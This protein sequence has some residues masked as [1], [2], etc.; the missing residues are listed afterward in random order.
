MVGPVWPV[1]PTM[2]VNGRYLARPSLALA[3]FSEPRAAY[4]AGPRLCFHVVA[5]RTGTIA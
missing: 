4:R 3:N 1:V 5:Q 2:T